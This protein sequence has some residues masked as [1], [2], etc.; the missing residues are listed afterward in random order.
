MAIF[1]FKNFYFEHR[2]ENEIKAN[3]EKDAVDATVGPQN[4]FSQNRFYGLWSPQRPPAS[5]GVKLTIL[6]LYDIEYV[7]IQ[8]YAIGFFL[9]NFLGSKNFRP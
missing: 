1:F 7:Y 8:H 2:C 6:F 4:S 5:V 3:S 9:L